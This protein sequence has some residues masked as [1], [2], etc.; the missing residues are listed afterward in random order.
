MDRLERLRQDRRRIEDLLALNPSWNALC[1]LSAPSAS[2]PAPDGEQAARQKAELRAALSG[3][4]L[5]VAHEGL[6]AA[7]AAL[8]AL[9]LPVPDVETAATSGDAAGAGAIDAAIGASSVTGP[10]VTGPDVTGLDVTGPDVTGPDDN[11]PDDNGPADVASSSAMIADGLRRLLDVAPRRNVGQVSIPAAR[12]TPH[13]ASAVSLPRAEIGAALIHAGPP[14]HRPAVAVSPAS[15]H[16]PDDL[17]RIRGINGA[18]ASALVAR[19]IRTFEEIA[20]FSAADVR[21]LAAALGLGTRISREN[22]IEQAAVLSARRARPSSRHLLAPARKSEIAASPE[23]YALPAGVLVTAAAPFAR[24]AEAAAKQQPPSLDDVIRAAALRIA[25]EQR[26]RAADLPQETK[27]AEDDAVDHALASEPEFGTGLLPVSAGDA[28][29]VM[30]DADKESATFDAAAGADTEADT[31]T[32]LQITAFDPEPGEDDLAGKAPE[33]NVDEPVSEPVRA[34]DMEAIRGIDPVLAAALSELG[35]FHWQEIADWREADVRVAREMLGPHARISADGWIEQ[36]AVLQRGQLT[37]YAARRDRLEHL[38][39]VEAPTEIPAR[40]PAFAMWLASHSSSLPTAT[41]PDAQQLVS[42][43]SPKAAEAVGSEVAGEGE[44]AAV[45]HVGDGA[46]ITGTDA[47][48]DAAPAESIALVEETDWFEETET[49]EEAGTLEVA[50][51]DDAMTAPPAVEAGVAPAVDDSAVSPTADDASAASTADEEPTEIVLPYDFKVA[52]AEADTLIVDPGAPA[53]DPDAIVP[54]PLPPGYNKV[55]RTLPHLPMDAGETGG[56]AHSIATTSDRVASQPIAAAQALSIADR[57][58]AIERDMA[59]FDRTPYP[60]PRAERGA[61]LPDR[62]PEPLPSH[63][64]GG[65]RANAPDDDLL[66]SATSGIE[67]ETEADVTIVRRGFDDTGLE[68]LPGSAAPD[69]AGGPHVDVDKETYA[70][71]RDR[72]EEASVEI[73]AISPEEAEASGEGVPAGA[74]GADSPVQ[75]F[76]KALKGS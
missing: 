60:P 39:L 44:D 38:A 3:E 63:T 34:D 48:S 55:V 68:P 41:V 13:A 5:F 59:R 73:V 6:A 40:D 1:W 22:W 62:A 15:P 70:A 29:A 69:F 56:D 32:D 11:G 42:H 33:G 50:A 66:A 16:T 24:A 31:D 47:V 12:S 7:I 52:N 30:V 21:A 17:T 74:S 37:A 10:D 57:I 51:P 20:H 64:D 26:Q 25:D 36:A 2:D 18:L 43:G 19:G 53:A 61:A 75:R 71:Y 27:G 9:C 4:P 72:V 14:G 45:A 54:P 35:I 28:A 76:L 8:E 58:T 49:F 65:S 67:A 46:A 23:A